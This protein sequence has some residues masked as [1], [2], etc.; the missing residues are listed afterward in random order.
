M[1]LC[2]PLCKPS[3]GL[4]SQFSNKPSGEAMVEMSVGLVPASAEAID[5]RDQLAS[6]S[7][8]QAALRHKTER[9]RTKTCQLGNCQLGN[10]LGTDVRST[11]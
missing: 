8:Q 10:C 5:K 2:K 11:L 6:I 3:E 7:M 1:T 9:A 4:R